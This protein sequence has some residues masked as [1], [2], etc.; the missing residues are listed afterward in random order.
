MS[1]TKEE[2]EWITCRLVRKDEG[3]KNTTIEI[4]KRILNMKEMVS[5]ATKEVKEINQ[6]K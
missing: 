6:R 3:E 1:G 2:I 4:V 5:E